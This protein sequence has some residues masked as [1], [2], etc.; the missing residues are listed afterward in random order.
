M[1]DSELDPYVEWIASEARRSVTTDPAARERI[2]AAVRAEPAPARRSG[3]WSRLVAPLEFKL[4]PAGGA[5]LAAGL[6]GIGV[7]VGTFAINRDGQSTVGRSS[8]AAAPQLPVSV[9]D[10]VVRFVYVAPQAS[11]VYL[12][13]DFNEW[14]A[15][16]TPLV[17]EGAKGGVWTVTV[18][19]SAGRHL[20]GFVVDG[21]WNTDPNAP[22]SP[23][24]GFGRANSVKLVRRGSA[25]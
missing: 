11:Q 24:D 21:S 1:T 19:L 13:G 23:D 12:V 20:Y 6:V 4:S 14:D 5:L 3:V 22:L 9:T 17:R 7:L 16:R 18:P 10:T 25:L 15:T 8:V 2:M